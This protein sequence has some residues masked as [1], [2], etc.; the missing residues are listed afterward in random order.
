MNFKNWVLLTET[1]QSI[2]INQARQIISS[3]AGPISVER[4][5]TDLLDSAAKR[6]DQLFFDPEFPISNFGRRIQ[7]F[8]MDG[9]LDIINTVFQSVGLQAVQTT[10]EIKSQN[11]AS[12]LQQIKEMLP[13][14]IVTILPD[15]S[16]SL[17]DG[18]HRLGVARV[19]N[20]PTL[21]AFIIQ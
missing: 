4:L 11:I 6:G 13:P 15:E 14:L 20:I 21:K 16:Y 2:D 3:H 17:G 9:V 10:Q 19:L 12:K 5:R 1:P 7:G 18:N 8:S